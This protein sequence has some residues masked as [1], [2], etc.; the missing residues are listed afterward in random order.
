MAKSKIPVVATVGVTILVAVLST[1]L[2]GLTV[3][4]F[5][6]ETVCQQVPPFECVAP[7]IG[8]MHAGV[9]MFGIVMLLG[10]L[11][12]VAGLFTSRVPLLGSI[13]LMSSLGVVGLGLI[14]YF[15]DINELARIFIIAVIL[16]VVLFTALFKFGVMGG[17]R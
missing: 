6:P 3:D 17:R 4:Y 13:L 12:Y 14:R 5:E 9:V 15:G 2:V 1:F 16:V 8:G 11:L 7:E 10:V